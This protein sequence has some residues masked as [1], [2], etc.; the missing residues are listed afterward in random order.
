M[1]EETH[2]KIMTQVT[3]IFANENLKIGEAI[4]VWWSLGMFLFSHADKE[5]NTKAKVYEAMNKYIA[6][7][8]KEESEKEQ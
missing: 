7:V 4:S 8:Q 6:T 2:D 5:H 1:E 3:K